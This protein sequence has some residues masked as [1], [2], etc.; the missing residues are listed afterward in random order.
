MIDSIFEILNKRALP[1]VLIFDAGYRLLYFN[2]EAA[3]ILSGQSLRY[4]LPEERLQVPETV[5]SLCDRLKKAAPT[6]SPVPGASHGCEL[7]DV[8][9][10]GQISLRASYIGQLEGEAPQHILVL[11]E[12]IME[13]RGVDLE[14]VQKEYRFSKKELEV[15]RHV[16]QGF[17]NRKIAE[18]MFI[19]EYT[20]KNHI[21]S[22]MK[23]M[24]VTSRS[25]ILA[26]MR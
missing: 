23:R 25:E 16:C 5:I 26:T 12:R 24:G 9:K 7:L 15:L 6:G 3:E 10:G 11:I 13:K 19:S 2:R 14:R 8:V 21:K 1:G 20:V 22:I 17:S 18:R 4:G